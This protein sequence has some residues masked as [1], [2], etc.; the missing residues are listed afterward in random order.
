MKVSVIVALYNKASYVERAI[1]SILDQTFT[2]FEIIV[3]ND[4]SADGS[5][6][7]VEAI[8]KYFN[9]KV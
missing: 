9:K 1:R 5:D 2:D 6:K 7:V 4:G 8:E 3:V